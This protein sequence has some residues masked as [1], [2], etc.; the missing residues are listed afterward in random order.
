VYD[1]I[2]NKKDVAF[3]YLSSWWV[4]CLCSWRPCCCRACE[5]TKAPPWQFML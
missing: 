5:Y 3:G 2:V 1:I 4:S